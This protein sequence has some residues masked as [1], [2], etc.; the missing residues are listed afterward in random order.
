MTGAARVPFGEA[1]ESDVEAIS[2]TEV[3]VRSPAHSAGTI[4]VVVVTGGGKSGTGPADHFA[5]LGAPVIA[6]ARG[7]AMRHAAVRRHMTAKEKLRERIE[8]LSK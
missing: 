3:K 7:T 2:A 8:A 5:Y 4:N 1:E 6:R